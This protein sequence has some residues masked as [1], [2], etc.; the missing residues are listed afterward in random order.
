[1]GQKKH[2]SPQ[3]YTKNSRQLTKAESRRDGLPRED[4]THWFFQSQSVLKTYTQVTLYKVNMLCL[5]ICIYTNIY[6]CS[7]NEKEAMNL[8]NWERYMG[9]FGGMKRERNVAN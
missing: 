7:N 9:V 5:G 6:A 8:K 2:T 4:R 3:P 1:M